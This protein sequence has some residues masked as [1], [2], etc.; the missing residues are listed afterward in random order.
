M[1]ENRLI[2]EKQWG[3]RKGRSTEGLLLK[4]TETWK[5]K[6]DK[7]FTIGVVFI[8]FQKAFDTVS[9]DVLSYKLQ[10]CGISAD[11]H[12]LIMNYLSGRKQDTEVNNQ[13]S[14]TKPVNCG[15]PQGSLLGQGSTPY[16]LT[17]SLSLQVKESCLSSPMIQTCIV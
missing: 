15:V 1:N 7:G 12:K 3:F 14:S 8:D 17:I 16:K 5:A 10:A 13:K 4:L 11:L 6:I 9:H 2:S